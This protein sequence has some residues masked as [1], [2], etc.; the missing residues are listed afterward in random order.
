MSAFRKNGK[1]L[2]DY[3]HARRALVSPCSRMKE[4]RAKQAVLSHGCARTAY[5]VRGSFGVCC[6]P[7]SQFYLR[8]LVWRA[9]LHAV[10]RA[11]NGSAQRLASEPA[12]RDVAENLTARKFF[13]DGKRDRP[14]YSSFQLTRIPKTRTITPLASAPCRRRW[15]K[16]CLHPKLWRKICPDESRHVCHR[17]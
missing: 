11:F 5:F 8:Y 3:E 16:C 1:M 4:P 15:G 17:Q 12:K 7:A 13:Q 10:D 14:H 2:R 6:A 9:S